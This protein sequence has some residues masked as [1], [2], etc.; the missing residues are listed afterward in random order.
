MATSG[1]KKIS[2]GKIETRI[3]NEYNYL[4][5]TKHN[6]NNSTPPNSGSF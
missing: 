5:H 6:E 4:P 1:V 3:A 2:T